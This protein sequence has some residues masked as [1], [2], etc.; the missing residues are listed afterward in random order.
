[1]K[2]RNGE[3]LQAWLRCSRFY[4]LKGNWYFS[5]R[6]G[7]E[8]G[9]FKTREEAAEELRSFIQDILNHKNNSQIC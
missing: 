6:E 2:K 9:P 3:N 5:T 4:S 8:Y 7:V 1:M